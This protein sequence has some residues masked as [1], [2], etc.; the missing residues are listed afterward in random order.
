ML[1]QLAA[2]G[3]VVEANE[4]VPS[5]TAAFW[6][7]LGSD[8]HKAQQ[9]LQKTTISLR[10][11]GQ[12]DATSLQNALSALDIQVVADGDV[13]VV[14]T[15]D[16]L[17]PELA[18]IN[19]EMLRNGRVWLLCKLTGT[20]PWI[21]PL[22][23]PSE[24][25]CWHCLSVRLRGNRQVESY[26]QKKLAPT[27][28]GLAP[29]ASL[30]STIAIAANLAATELFKWLS[31]TTNGQLH[32]QLLT[33]N[34]ATLELEKH[35]LTQRPQCLSCG[36]PE[37]LRDYKTPRPISLQASLKQASNDGGHRSALPEETLAR[38]QK[39][40]SPLTGV[41]SSLESLF[42]DSNGLTYSYAAG[43][44][45]AMT[46][47][48][49]SILR[50]NLRARSG[51][52]G[53]TDVQAKVSAIGEAM[54]R[55]SG[56][57]RGDD[58]ITHAASYRELGD[59]AIHL[60]DILLFSPQ[61]YENRHEWNKARTTNF[62]LV[63]NLFDE[64]KVIDWTPLWSLTNQNFKYVPTV[65]CY[66][67]HPDLQYFYCGS[68]SNGCS[69]G[70]TLEEAILQGFFELV[71]RDAVAMWWYNRV[72]RP[73]LHLPSFNNPYTQTLTDFYHKHNRSLWVLDITSDLGIPVFAAISGR[74]DKEAEDIIVGFGA[75][76]DPQIA[77]MRALSEVN[78]LLS[79][80][81]YTHRDGNT[82]YHIND[83]ETL[84]WF[85][86]ARISDLTYLAPADHLAPR[87]LSGFEQVY[88][89]DIKQDIEHCLEIVR[90]KGLDMLALDMTRPDVGMN[91]CRVIVPGLRHFWRRLGA[92]RLYD[93]PVQMGWLSKPISEDELNPIS[94]FF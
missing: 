56:V 9:A 51:G 31:Q 55:Y 64:E 63:P 22:F 85:T 81:W 92:G 37:F 65:Y 42:Q 47:D 6:H 53:M 78:Q 72:K 76:L 20:T 46:Q 8:T 29:R 13:L 2:R 25:A 68:D 36:D 87:T 18:E 19:E 61:Q 35:A 11:I 3:F 90:G 1:H 26:I 45:F 15:D 43:H 32:N 88:H 34:T 10:A 66:F 16:Y 86:K 62:H 89:N 75:H 39:N 41:V 7:I 67:G 93:V 12:S 5:E 83:Q 28:P 48:D 71:E 79:T 52:K 54:E 50:R 77:L 91:A 30:A 33:Y 27:T 73:S 84:D 70:N 40:I 74:T 57:F 49:M 44:N 23:I 21:G 80:V 17:R 38:H 82:Q 59:K 60:D 24:T 69:A 14:V 94:M 58:E 4:A